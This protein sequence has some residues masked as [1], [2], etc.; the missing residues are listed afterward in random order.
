[1]W[2]TIHALTPQR[3]SNLFSSKYS[4][5]DVNYP[6]NF[7]YRIVVDERDAYNTIGGIQLGRRMGNEAVCVK[8]A[9][10]D[11]DLCDSGKSET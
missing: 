7:L 10:A 5:Q 3:R 8:M 2:V 6:L 1:M 11:T 9:K 4:T